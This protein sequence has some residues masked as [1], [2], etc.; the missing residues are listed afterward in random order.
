MICIFIAKNYRVLA[1]LSGAFLMQLTMSFVQSI[2]RPKA[3]LCEH[4][5]ILNHY[6]DVVSWSNIVN[7]RLKGDILT[8]NV[9]K[10]TS[11]RERYDV[12]LSYISKKEELLDDIKALC[13]AKNI[14]FE[15][16]SDQTD[17]LPFSGQE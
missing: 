10:H 6:Q 3:C 1:F 8:F 15:I 14:P 13:E 7:A 16:H 2:F 5:L 17:L 9:Q 11:W 12:S 4:F